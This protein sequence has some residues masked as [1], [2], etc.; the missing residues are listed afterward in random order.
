MVGAEDDVEDDEVFA[1]IGIPFRKLFRM[2]PA[3]Q[4]RRAEDIIEQ[5]CFHIDVAMGQNTDE[6][7]HRTQPP[8]NLKRCAH[9]IKRYLAER[10]LE[11]GIGHMEPARIHHPETHDAVMQRMEPPEK[12]SFM[13]DAMGPVE[14]EFGNRHRKRDLHHHWQMRWPQVKAHGRERLQHVC[15]QHRENGRCGCG[16]LHDPLGQKRMADAGHR[17]AIPFEPFDLVGNITLEKKE[18]DDRTCIN[19]EKRCDRMAAREGEVRPYEAATKN[20]WPGRIGQGLFQYLRFCHH[21][22]IPYG[23]IR[24]S[25]PRNL[26]ASKQPLTPHNLPDRMTGQV[27]I[28][29]RRYTNMAREGAE[30]FSSL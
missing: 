1:V 24:L 10:D 21:N 16:K 30:M 20:E 19:T 18:S 7:G 17:L 12:N 29:S 22:K 4:A 6:G 14:A 2:V 28:T 5:P 11:Q 9:E 23:I 15:R 26:A 3:V 25:H 13:G 8:E 27:F